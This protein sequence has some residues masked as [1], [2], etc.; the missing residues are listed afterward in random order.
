MILFS[1]R[2]DRHKN[3]INFYKHTKGLLFPEEFSGTVK[4]WHNK[5]LNGLQNCLGGVSKQK[6]FW[7]EMEI[8]MKNIF[9]LGLYYL[10]FSP[11]Y[12]R[13]FPLA[14]DLGCGRGHISKFLT[15]VG[16]CMYIYRYKLPLL[17]SKME[18]VHFMRWGR[19]V[20]HIEGKENDWKIVMTNSFLF[21]LFVLIFRNKLELW[22]C[23]IWQRIC[24]LVWLLYYYP[25]I[26]LF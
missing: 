1:K 4:P 6:T 19:D 22:S 2:V 18:I 23:L 8:S 17:H 24:W 21:I 11:C 15:K 16:T 5:V 12:F 26:R 10:Y 25:E 3:H 13:F 20:Q 9:W 7:G 14:L